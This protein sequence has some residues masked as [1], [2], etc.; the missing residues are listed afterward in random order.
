MAY[1]Q[2]ENLLYKSSKFL[3]T[4][5]NRITHLRFLSYSCSEESHEQELFPAEW[6]EN[7]F[8]RLKKLA[9]SLKHVDLI[10]GR[11]V[12][13]NEDARVFD[14]KL[15]EKMLAFKSLARDY[16]GCPAMQETMRTNVVKTFGDSQCALPMY[17]GKSSERGPLTLNS[18]TK[19]SDILNVSAQQRK[20]VR[21]TVCPQV[22][23]HQIWAGALEGTLNELRSEIDYR[24]QECPRKEIKMAQQIVASCLKLLT[25]A[26][27]YDPEST[28]WMRIAPTKVAKSSDH[29]KWEDVLEMVIDLVNCLN[30]QEEFV[31]HVKKLE[32]MKEG[33]YQIRD[34]L[35]DKS[36]GYKESRHQESLVQ[37]KLTKTLGH[38]SR[39]LFT[40]LLYYLYGSVL[41]IEVEV[42]GGCYPIE[43]QNQFCL[44]MGKILTSN[45]ENM[46]WGGVKQLDRALGLFK[47]VWETAGMKGDLKLQGHLWCIGAE[48]RTV[49]YKGNTF[50]LHGI[51]YLPN[52]LD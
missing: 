14:R 44:F 3:R 9:Q 47:F 43:G 49:T 4:K 39:C 32:S 10:D 7:T 20:L 15:E 46:V 34:I 2:A 11:L 13:V 12:K 18:L 30:D 24:I 22:T 36:I 27:S 1:K 40:L 29:H 33:L 42:R 17:F 8:L 21:L 16:I 6:Y 50:L 35:I 45:E 26:I 41:D 25:A 31:L 51:N 5:Q 48:S 23:Q 52:G 38:P 37:K 28:S 19:I